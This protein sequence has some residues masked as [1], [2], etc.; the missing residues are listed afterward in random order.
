[1]KSQQDS[2][3][4]RHLALLTTVVV[5]L[6]GLG[7]WVNATPD[8]GVQAVVSASIN[9]ATGSR[10]LIWQE[11]DSLAYALSV[12]GIMTL[13]PGKKNA[14]SV[15]YNLDALLCGQVLETSK[16]KAQV[17]MQ[18]RNLT[19]EHDGIQD[20]RYQGAMALPFIVLFEDGMPSTFKF[21]GGLDAEVQN[22]LSELIRTFQVKLPDK[23]SNKWSALEAHQNGQYR[24]S[25]QIDSR[26]NWNK[27]K[28]EYVS[29]STNASNFNIDNIQIIQSSATLRPAKKNSWWQ[30]AEIADEIHFLVDRSALVSVSKRSTLNAITQGC[31]ENSDLANISNPN[32]LLNVTVSDEYKNIQPEEV[33]ARVAGPEDFDRFRNL[34]ST[35]IESNAKNFTDVHDLADMLKEFPELSAEIPIMLTQNELPGM[36]EAGLIHALELAGNDTAK[37]VLTEIMSEPSYLFPNRQRSIIGLSRIED[38]SQ[39]S[40]ETLWQLT[41]NRGAPEDESLANSALMALGTISKNMR[42]SGDDSYRDL[43]SHLGANLAGQD[44]TRKLALLSAMYNSKDPD[45]LVYAAPELEALQSNVRIAAIE[46]IA[47]VDSPKSF[48]LIHN[49]LQY[50]N[51]HRVRRALVDGIGKLSHK[52]VSVFEEFV[53][54]IESEGNEDVRASMA[55][56][57]ADNIDVYPASRKT[58][59]EYLD[60][61]KNSA[62]YRADV[63]SRM[64]ASSGSKSL[65]RP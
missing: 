18:L 46:A 62:S 25:Y 9:K 27:N 10:H 4:K 15:D 21:P 50:E 59:S 45:L 65:V 54:D 29:V 17:A 13:N 36:V 33:V 24:A 31:D 55:R 38:P 12:K 5:C 6:V 16:G 32:D 52:N 44:V 51:D 34:A 47:S 64:R 1:M 41:N 14:T 19:R 28:T 43:S 3:S 42:E 56:Y 40:I 49:R 26:G 2:W 22:E 30:E 39:E 58:L 48:D 37:N 53:A 7:V 63:S 8:K 60:N 23:P 20:A 11:N 57:L 61:S 35:F